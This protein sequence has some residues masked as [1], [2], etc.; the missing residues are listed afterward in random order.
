MSCSSPCGTIDGVP[1]D[2]RIT[3]SHAT[4]QGFKCANFDSFRA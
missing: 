1:E 2:A 3:N 4:E